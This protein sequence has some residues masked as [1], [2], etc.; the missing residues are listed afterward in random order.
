MNLQAD[1]DKLLED[2]A[3]ENL[4]WLEEE[5]SCLFKQKQ[6]R[7]CYTKDDI[8]M[9]NQILDNVIGNIKENENEQTLNLLA[10]TLNKL[11]RTYP[12]FF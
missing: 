9:G 2:N 6:L 12:E 1:Y 5:F 8:S 11:E 4:E 10:I 3:R 7:H